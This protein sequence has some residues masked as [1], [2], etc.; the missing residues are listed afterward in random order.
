MSLIFRSIINDPIVNELK[1]KIQEE[2][3]GS[4][5]PDELQSL[6]IEIYEYEINDQI[7][8]D[9]D[10]NGNLIVE[11]LNSLGTPYSKFLIEGIKPHY[12]Q[13]LNKEEAQ[14]SLLYIITNGLP[15]GIIEI[16]YNDIVGANKFINK[17]F[18]LFGED[19]EFFTNWR[20]ISYELVNGLQKPIFSS[21]GSG[22]GIFN[23]YSLDFYADEVFIFIGNKKIG[24]LGFLGTD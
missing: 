1:S 3:C 8:D 13:R 16:F 19:C 5:D 10:I 9:N 7:N 11:F 2:A 17:L 4:T 12:F 15:C 21:S 6:F 18:G 14:L 22:F 24:F 23:V 20:R